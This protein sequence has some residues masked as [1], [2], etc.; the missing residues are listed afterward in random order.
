MKTDIYTKIA[1]GDCYFPRRISFSEYDTY[2][3]RQ[4]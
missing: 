3:L 1:D 4:S 2:Y